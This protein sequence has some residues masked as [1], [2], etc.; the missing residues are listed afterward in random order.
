MKFSSVLIFSSSKLFLD[1]IQL[2][3]KKIGELRNEESTSTACREAYDQT[4]AKHHTFIIRNGARVA[5]YTLPTKIV[6]LRKVR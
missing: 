5:I 2:F 6:L 4:L 3:L 1:F